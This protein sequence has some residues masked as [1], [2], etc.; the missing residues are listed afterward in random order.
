MARY[1][2]F[3]DHTA[4]ERTQIVADLRY[5]KEADS[6]LW[7]VDLPG[8]PTQPPLVIRAINEATAEARFKELCGLISI[9]SDMQIQVTPYQ[10]SPSQNGD[11]HDDSNGYHA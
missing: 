3:V 6:P 11:Q 7:A 2:D 8:D 10:P 1:R 9:G 4:Q 5:A